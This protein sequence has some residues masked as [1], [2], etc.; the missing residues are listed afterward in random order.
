LKS[1]LGIGARYDNSDILLAKQNKRVLL[2]TTVY[3]RLNQLNTFVYLEENLAISDKINIV[4]GIRFDVFNFNFNDKLYDSASGNAIKSRLSPKL[5]LFYT[6]V[7]GL[8]FFAK[9]GYGFHSNDAR[10]VV[11][12]KLENTLPRAF[13]YEGGATFKLFKSILANVAIW[14]LDLESELIYVGD[15]GVVEISGRT[16]RVGIDFGVRQQIA[17]HF[18]AD[19]DMNINRGCLRDEPEGANAIPLA[20]KF[21]SIGGLTYKREKG[22]NGSL[23]YKYVADRPANETNT[24][25]AKGYFLLDATLNYAQ[26]KWQIGLSA[27]NLLNNNWNEAQ[28]DTE[29]RLQHEAEPISELHFTPGTP[30]F[31]KG[32]LAYFF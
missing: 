17:K 7:N 27:E 12:G 30:F 11:A 10:A 1:T 19:I 25:T 26:P 2:D 9:A 6:P 15:E 24:V 3:G 8:Q 28:F 31:M 4:P 5:N 14:D 22:L 23:R 13:G 20:P 21:T 32:S 16:R 18:F 29:S